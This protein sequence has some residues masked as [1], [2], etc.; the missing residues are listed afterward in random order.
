MVTELQSRKRDDCALDEEGASGVSG[1]SWSCS[2]EN[3]C[4]PM[5]FEAKT[6]KGMENA[7]SGGLQ[8]LR[9]SLPVGVSL[10]PRYCLRC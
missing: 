6:E 3:P 5:S 7:L 1:S 9:S 8:K 4:C 2:L 10:E